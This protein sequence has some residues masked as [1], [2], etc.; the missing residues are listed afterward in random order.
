[1]NKFGIII[2][3]VRRED[4]WKGTIHR[5]Y[6]NEGDAEVAFNNLDDEIR[7][8]AH[9]V[10]LGDDWEEGDTFQHTMQ[11]PKAGKDIEY[12]T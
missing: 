8:G 1:M 3:T 5:L 7:K 12:L 2:E 6:V 4:M 9:I 10:E 11:N